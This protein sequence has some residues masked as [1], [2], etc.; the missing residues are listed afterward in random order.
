MHEA[1]DCIGCMVYQKHPLCLQV[2]KNASHALL[3]E[4]DV[5][6]A[7]LLKQKGFYV[8]RRDMS[9]PMEKRM[10]SSF[11]SAAPIEK[12]T[13]EELDYYSDGYVHPFLP[14]DIWYDLIIVSFMHAYQHNLHD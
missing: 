7:Q 12:P 3:Q 2:F 14:V 4:A 9:A 11:G 6:L 1:V 5:N 13:I 8:T 10:K